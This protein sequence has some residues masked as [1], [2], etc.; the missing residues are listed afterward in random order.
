VLYAFGFDKVG[1]VV[2]DLYFVNPSPAAGQEG[3]E[4]G[5]RLELRLLAPGELHGSIFS[6][7]PIRVDDPIW[8]VDLLETVTSEPGSLNR[9]HHHPRFNGWEPGTRVFDEELSA[10]PVAWVGKQLADLPALLERA[11]I[12][13]DASFEPD[14]EGVHE[15]V[16]EIVNAVRNLLDGVKAG[17]LGRGPEGD[18]PESA[19]I[20]WL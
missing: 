12:D 20:S 19:R 18:E 3:A 1:V 8:R 2:S 9:A 17:K 11:G 10:E 6:A 4:R 15:R 16:P 14:I 7:R 5:V 13:A